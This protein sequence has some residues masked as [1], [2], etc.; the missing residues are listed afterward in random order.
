MGN[1]TLG[2]TGEV[3]RAACECHKDQFGVVVFAISPVDGRRVEIEFKI[4]GTEEEAN[5]NLT[6]FT[7]E[8]AFRTVRENGLEPDQAKEI[9][10]K[11]GDDALKAERDLRSKINETLH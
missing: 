5:K 7:N 3:V 2:F 6:P 11:H 4:F 8:V 10:V 1:R 9:V